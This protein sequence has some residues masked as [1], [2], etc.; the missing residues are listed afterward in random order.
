MKV[1]KIKKNRVK[2]GRSESNRKLKRYELN[3]KRWRT[4]EK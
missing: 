4:R 3:I 1:V 2:R